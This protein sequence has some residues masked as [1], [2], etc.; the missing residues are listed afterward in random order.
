MR[1]VKNM[2]D[3]KGRRKS[4]IGT[5]T[6]SATGIY[7]N[8]GGLTRKKHAGLMTRTSKIVEVLRSVKN[9]A[10]EKVIRILLTF[11]GRR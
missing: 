1:F 5:D 3:I 2:N 10:N 7:D 6:V 4:F 11:I 9:V 8:N